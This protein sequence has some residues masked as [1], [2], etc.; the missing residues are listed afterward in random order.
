MKFSKNRNPA[1]PGFKAVGLG[2]G[3]KAG[4]LKDL[5]LIVSDV[6]ATAA[7]VFTKNRVVSPGVTWS[8]RALAKSGGCRAIVVNSGNANAVVGPK[9]L[10]DCDTI[11]K[12]IA[13]ELDVAFL[14]EIPLDVEIRRKSDLGEPVSLNNNFEV[15]S[16]FKDIAKQIVYFIE[17]ES[18]KLNV[19]PT[20]NM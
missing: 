7:G 14:G 10:K 16:Y 18:I 5:A 13:E 2:C 4:N 17:N 6:P 19:K 20:I 3:I 15:N 1:V 12:K 8:R 11:T 9:G